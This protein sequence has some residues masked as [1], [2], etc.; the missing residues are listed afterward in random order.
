RHTR[1]PRDWSSDVCSSDLIPGQEN[2]LQ[3]IASRPG[4]Y[5]GQCA[6]FCGW[7]HAH[8]GLVVVA[9]PIPMFQAWLSSQNQPATEPDDP[10]RKR[11]EER[12][13]GKEG[14]A[15]SATW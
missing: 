5:R 1:W 2:E 8:M 10:V 9:L 4:I 6:E 15:R 11:S 13:V 7:Q 12:R 14:R 3:F